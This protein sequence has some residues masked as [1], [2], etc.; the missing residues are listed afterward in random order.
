MLSTYKEQA[1][2]SL[3]E[4]VLTGSSAEERKTGQTL[5]T[6]IGNGFASGSPAHFD[7]KYALD[8]AHFW[9]FLQTTQAKELAKV[10]RAPDWQLKILERYDRLVKKY[11]VLRVLKK[12]LEVDDAHFT[13]FYEWPSASSA[14]SIK[15]NFEKNQFSVTR[16]LRYSQLHAGEEID[17]VLFVNGIPLLTM[18]LKNAWTGQTAAVQ[19]QKQYKETRDTSQTLFQFGRCLV[20]FAADTDEV[21]MTSKL[22]GKNTFFLPFNKG[23]HFGKGNPVNP[24]G[25]KTAYLWEEIFTK[26]SLAT[27]IQHFVLLDGKENEPLPKKQFIFPRYHQLDVVSKIIED[28]RAKGVGQTYLI[29][30]SAGSGKSNSITWTAFQLIEVEDNTG[31]N[32]FDTVIVVTDRRVLDKQLRDNIKHFS[33]IKNIVGAAYTSQDL[34][35]ALEGGKRIIVTTIQKFPHIVHDIGDMADK[36]FAVVIDEAHSSQGGT[37]ADT[38]N[39]VIGKLDTNEEG[40]IDTQEFINQVMLARKMRSNASYFA[41]TATPK[42]STLERFGQPNGAGGFEPFHLYSMKQ[43]IEEGFILDVLANYTTYESYYHLEK[44]V[45]D[46]PEFNTKKAQKALRAYVEKDKRTITAK[47]EVMFAHFIQNVYAKKK[48]EGKAKGMV[49]TQNIESAIHYYTALKEQLH[50]HGNPFDIIIAFSGKKELHGVTYTEASLN[51]FAD[52]ETKEQFD[53]DRYRL[54]VVANKYLT[55]FDQPKL[56]VMYVDK[57]LEG[58]LCVQALSRLNRAA[59]RYNK[60]TEDLFVLDFFNASQDIKNAFDL[61]YSSTSLLEA[62]DVNVL[63]DLKDALDDSGVYEQSEITQFNEL[64]F[65]QEEGEII[66]SLIDTA[67]AR[68]NEELYLT[69]DQKADLKVKAKH[70]VKIYG[71]VAAILNFENIRWEKLFWFLKFLIPKMLVR[72]ASSEIDG[73]LDAVDLSTYGLKRVKLN[74][75]IALDAAETVLDAVSSNPRSAH[76]VEETEDLETILQNFNEHWYTGWDA[77]AEDKHEIFTSFTKR[78]TQHPDFTTKYQNNTDAYTRELAFKKI[79]DDVAHAL[80]RL[81]IDFAKQLLDDQFKQDF[82]DSAQ[83]RLR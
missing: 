4:K 74:E 38:M 56:S 24:N 62:T 70:F 59:P 12:G 6:E 29:Q 79:F 66:T 42:P 3:I 27:I 73:L 41:F 5:T 18:E 15:D 50:K 45:E 77:T 20:H 22:D 82:R 52:T 21:Y 83:R 80:S 44:S 10:Q 35:L 69:D 55:G 1:L 49:I 48:L 7:K 9:N 25:F 72:N 61:Y 65:R 57:K 64:F 76:N 63:H 17:M 34:R 81:N 31:R 16:Q 43:A 71:Q 53:Q 39:A 46:N 78:I 68:F 26:K 11:G 75:K 67:A 2:E 37:A 36:R 54:L 13:L 32:L 23:N 28:V 19:G 8:T 60:R 33:E 47:A 51:G 14:Q 58:V 30:H 40:E